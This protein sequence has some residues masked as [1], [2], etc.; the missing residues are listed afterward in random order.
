MLA[1]LDGQDTGSAKDLC[2]DEAVTGAKEC[3]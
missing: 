3:R 1:G 2:I